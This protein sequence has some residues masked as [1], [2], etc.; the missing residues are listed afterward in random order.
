[1]QANGKDA[2]GTWF[3]GVQYLKDK[4]LDSVFVASAKSKKIG[5]RGG[6]MSGLMSAVSLS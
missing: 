5:I 3:D 4:E 2:E 1:M 6:G